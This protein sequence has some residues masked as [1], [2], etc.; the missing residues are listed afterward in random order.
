[1]DIG[2]NYI[3]QSA[4]GRGYLPR[5]A[6]RMIEDAWTLII[7]YPIYGWEGVLTPLCIEDDCGFRDIIM[8]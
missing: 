8:H 5:H 4:D 7:L 1:M 3:I 2:S 6:L